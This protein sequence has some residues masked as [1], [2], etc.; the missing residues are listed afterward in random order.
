MLSLFIFTW[1]MNLPAPLFYVCFCAKTYQREE[2]E[3]VVK[4][5]KIILLKIL[6]GFFSC[7]S[8]YV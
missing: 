3:S 1:K 5:A 6:F 2:I 4:R 8:L 7:H